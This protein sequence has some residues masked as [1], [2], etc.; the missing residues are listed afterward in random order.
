[1]KFF[2]AALIGAQAVY[3]FDHDLTVSSENGFVNSTSTDLANANT[4]ASA[5]LGLA[6]ATPATKAAFKG[7][8][9]L[10]SALSVLEKADPFFA[11]IG[12][13][14]SIVGFFGPDDTQLILDA[15]K[16]VSDQVTYL[17][18]DM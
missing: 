17:Q 1:M 12:M 18:G 14:S 10:N 7:A 9:A 4:A 13:V 15:I 5:M 8:A 3:A 16:G 2:A 11:V 6:N